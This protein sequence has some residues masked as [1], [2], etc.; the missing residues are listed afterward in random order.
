MAEVRAP[1]HFNGEVTLM[2]RVQKKNQRQI[3]CLKVFS[4]AA[5]HVGE[6]ALWHA[7]MSSQQLH[8]HDEEPWVDEELF[9]V[10]SSRF[11]LGSV[12]ERD[13]EH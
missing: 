4:P 2:A 7:K 3:I 1:L 11:P 8:Q 9:V 13:A 5:K 12:Q 6:L 10:L